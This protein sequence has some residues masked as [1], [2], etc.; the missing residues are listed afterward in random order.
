MQREHFYIR[1]FSCLSEATTFGKVIRLILYKETVSGSFHENFIFRQNHPKLKMS[2]FMSLVALLSVVVTLTFV[3]GA[4]GFPYV[5]NGMG[6]M[7]MLVIPVGRA[8]EPMSPMMIVPVMLG[9]QGSMM[10]KTMMNMMPKPMM[11]MMPNY[12]MPQRMMMPSTAPAMEKPEIKTD[13]AGRQ[14]LEF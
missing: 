7:G 13:A 10:A 5:N 2:P 11:P 9:N 6:N 12:P 3:Q 14:T 4:M 1:Q 8:E